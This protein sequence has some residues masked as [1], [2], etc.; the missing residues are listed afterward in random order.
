MG[1]RKR[2]RELEQRVKE[3]TAKGLADEATMKWQ[4]NRIAA[5]QKQLADRDD[6]LDK[7]RAAVGF[8]RAPIVYGGGGGGGRVIFK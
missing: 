8:A 7:I 1:K 2:I 3:L 5:Q 4:A 6:A